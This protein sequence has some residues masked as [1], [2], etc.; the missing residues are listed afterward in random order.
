MECIHK[1]QLKF[2]GRLKSSSCLLDSRLVV[3]IT[4]YGLGHL[5]HIT[6][7]TDNEKYSGLHISSF[8]S[9]K[10]TAETIVVRPILRYCPD[11]KIQCRPDKNRLLFVTS[12][13]DELERRST[14]QLAPYFY[15]EQDWYSACQPNLNIL[16]IS[17]A[18]RYYTKMSVNLTVGVHFFLLIYYAYARLNNNN[19]NNNNN[20]TTY[21][22]P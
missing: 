5:R 16:C 8:N 22:A 18:K 13:C 2:H 3:K 1:S 21:K 14:N 9:T 19:N 12:V 20:T 6:Y 4:D 15:L 17:S 7:D 10:P 11:H